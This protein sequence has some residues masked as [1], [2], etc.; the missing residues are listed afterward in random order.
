MSSPGPEMTAMKWTPFATRLRREI[1]ALEKLS[2]E[3]LDKSGIEY[4]G[5]FNRGGN[6]VFIAPDWAWADPT[7]ELR[8]LQM[9]LVP[10]FEE[11][12]ERYNLLFRTAPME[13]QEE[14]K[15]TL[16]RI[17]VWLARDGGGWTGWDVPQNITKAK[18]IQAERF[19]KLRQLLDVVAPQSTESGPVIALPDTSSLIDAPDLGRYAKALRVPS[20][21][22][23][24]VPAVLSELDSLK[25]QGKTQDVREKARRAIGAI[26]SIR[27]RGSLLQGV[28]LE[29]GVR[30]VSRPQEPRFDDLPGNLDRSVPDDR[31][32]AA[33]FEL[34]RDYP[35]AAVVLVT[36][37][38]NLQTK[39]ELAQIPFAEPPNEPSG[40]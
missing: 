15:E 32:L 4:R 16:G 3:L 21:D 10:R 39:A 7:D 8:R 26:K 12:R 18:A 5:D 17:R 19:A 9:K 24:L 37:D 31:L 36:G 22:L 20:L 11:W 33:A 13:L 29:G 6:V 25:D 2:E 23:F 14:A 1:D 40:W 30:V 28:D 38:V 34:Q 35:T 27:E